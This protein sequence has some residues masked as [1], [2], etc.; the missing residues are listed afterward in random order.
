MEN[1]GLLQANPNDTEKRQ[2][3]FKMRKPLNHAQQKS[4]IQLNKSQKCIKLVNFSGFFFFFED[5]EP[6][7]LILSPE[8]KP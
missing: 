1:P 5:L 4:E 3:G 6:V 8:L 2:N 7:G